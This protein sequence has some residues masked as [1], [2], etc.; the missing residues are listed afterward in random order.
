VLQINGEEIQ[1]SNEK[2]WI[3][4]NY[5]DLRLLEEEFLELRKYL[6]P[7]HGIK[8]LRKKYGIGS[9]QFDELI[10]PLVK[11]DVARR[12]NNK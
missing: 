12:K 6:G 5:L 10:A 2:F 4:P 1:I 9:E 3:D 11:K 8:E 7:L